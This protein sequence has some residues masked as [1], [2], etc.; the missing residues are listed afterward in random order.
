M[1]SELAKEIVSQVADGKLDNARDSINLG[2]QKASSEA[3]DMKRLE[4]QLDWQSTKIES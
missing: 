3:I 1:S 2:L 4:M